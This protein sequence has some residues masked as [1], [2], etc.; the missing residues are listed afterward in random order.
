[1]KFQHRVMAKALKIWAQVENRTWNDEQGL[2]NWEKI[3]FTEWKEV[4]KKLEYQ[5]V[6]SGGL[7]NTISITAQC[8]VQEQSQGLG[9]EE[10]QTSYK[11][12]SQYCRMVGI[13][14][15]IGRLSRPKPLLKWIHLEWVAQDHIQVGFDYI[16]RERKTFQE[17]SLH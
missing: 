10:I 7:E 3:D 13:G 16:S 11:K 5:I 9:A 8:V 14:M 2:K 4:S 12:W 17:R 6:T 15:A 1:M